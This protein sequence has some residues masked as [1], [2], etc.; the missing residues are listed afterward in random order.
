M[1]SSTHL[2]V[3]E[4]YLNND[5]THGDTEGHDS[6]VVP[7]GSVSHAKAQT[8]SAG[9]SVRGTAA[10]GSGSVTAPR[11]L[12]LDIECSPNLAYVWDV[13]K[14]NVNPNMLLETKEVLCFAYQWEGDRDIQ[15]RSQFHDGKANMLRVLWNVLDDA[16]V[17][18]DY[19]G[20]RYD[21]PH[22]NTDLLI[23]GYSPPSPYKHV[24]LFKTVR[25][26]FNF[27]Y[28]SLD[29]VCRK[30]G[31]VTK[32]EK[33]GFETWLGCIRNEP[34]AWANMKY[35]NIGD[36]PP[37]I[38]LHEKLRPWAIQ[39]PNL[40]LHS[41]DRRCPR[42]QST[43]IQFRGTVHTSAGVF[44]RF[45]CNECGSWGRMAHRISTTDVRNVAD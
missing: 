27:T 14:Q 30:L 26:K 37:L 11:V 44:K 21:I 12:Y 40:S 25:R 13:W 5:L 22:V 20:D 7:D 33:P 43:S 42:C 45:V 38:A 9:I 16:D 10:R 18:I 6:R 24:D 32:Q 31:I 39:Y 17:V 4:N 41:G 1:S 28:M 36:I 35:Y 3:L 23:A 15:F 8:G 34:A 2:F 19:N 29:H